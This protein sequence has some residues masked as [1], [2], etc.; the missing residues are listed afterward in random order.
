[1]MPSL[2]VVRWDKWMQ[3]VGGFVVFLLFGLGT[4]AVKMYK[5]WLVNI[6]LSGLFPGLR[7]EKRHASRFTTTPTAG[8]NLKTV[9]TLSSAFSSKRLSS[10]V[11]TKRS[12]RPDS[13]ART[14]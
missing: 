1:M 11:S 9:S 3:I 2:G 10:L 13:N 6:G 12:D 7:L 5:G 4:D 14:S 8:R